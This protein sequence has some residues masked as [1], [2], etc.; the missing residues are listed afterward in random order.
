ML[1]AFAVTHPILALGC[2]VFGIGGRS[3]VAFA[4][5]FVALAWLCS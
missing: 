5:A 3:F 4:A 2:V 1:T